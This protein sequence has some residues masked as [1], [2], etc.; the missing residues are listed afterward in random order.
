V[1]ALLGWKDDPHDGRGTPRDGF[2]LL[3]QVLLPYFNVKD[4]LSS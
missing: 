2:P 3:A 4:S 1:K